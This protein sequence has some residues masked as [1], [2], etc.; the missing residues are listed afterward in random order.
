MSTT[1]WAAPQ[2]TLLAAMLAPTRLWDCESWSDGRSVPRARSDRLT[3]AASSEGEPAGPRGAPR[4]RS[5]ASGE[6]RT[7][8]AAVHRSR[9]ACDD[10]TGPF[11]ARGPL[12]AAQRRSAPRTSTSA[13]AWAAAP[14]A[15]VPSRWNRHQPSSEAITKTLAISLEPLRDELSRLCVI[16][17][18]I[19]RLA[20]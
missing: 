13:R 10:P 4:T 19:L 20:A 18:L 2:Y 11:V 15:L 9:R 1:P 16:V 7:T 5:C 12:S 17:L 3:R 8:G 14:S 6:C